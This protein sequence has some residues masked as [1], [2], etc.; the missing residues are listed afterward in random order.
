MGLPAPVRAVVTV[1]MVFQLLFCWVLLWLL[2]IISIALMYPFTTLYQ[3]Q[4]VC[5][6]IHRG[7][8]WFFICL[9][10]PLWYTKMHTKCPT[11]KI[12]KD[13]P[14]LFMMNHLSN[15]DS[16]FAIRAIW[17]YDCKWIAK[18]VLFKLP[19]AGWG[20]K[21]AGDIAIKF[22]AEKG[23]WGTEKGSV[24]KMMKDAKEL[25]TV[26]RHPIAVYPE[27]VRNPKPEGPIGEFKDG[28]FMVAI[29]TGAW[30]VPVA[31][32]GSD[33][34]WPVHDWRFDAA[35]CHM[36]H[37]EPINPEGH[38]VE[39]LKKAVHEAMTAA[40]EAHPDRVALRNKKSE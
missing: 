30:I 38:T 8:N 37:C 7:V 25:L 20:M 9:L 32:S 29:E 19:F 34:A 39:S 40:R 12:P 24:G 23:G 22:T 5:G 33:R 10:N 11:D 21:L 6:Y 17:P 16:W 26:H 36:T 14:F 2:Q 13:K 27:G 35:T 15:S 18:G 3:R 28:F 1:C 4:N 31:L